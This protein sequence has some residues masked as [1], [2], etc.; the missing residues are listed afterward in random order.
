MDLI[1]KKQD[2]GLQP[3]LLETAYTLHFKV[4]SVEWP[5]ASQ[6]ACG[7]PHSFDHRDSGFDRCFELTPA[8]AGPLHMLIPASGSD[9][10]LTQCVK[11]SPVPR[12]SH[13]LLPVPE[14]L[15]LPM[16]R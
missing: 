14:A 9:L 13:W 2:P 1:L 16:P 4:G 12:P 7:S 11:H 10:T 6:L 3:Y 8:D 15:F 5:L